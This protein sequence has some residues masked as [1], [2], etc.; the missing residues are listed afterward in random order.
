MSHIEPIVDFERGIDLSRDELRNFLANVER[1]MKERPQVEVPLK[2][3]F[4]PGCYCR[5]VVLKK[6][7][8]AMGKIHKFPCL[9]IIASGE[10]TVLSIDGPMRVKAPFTF[11]SSPGAKR[12]VYAH[13]ETVW[14][15]VQGTDETDIAKIEEIFIAKD[16]D[17]IPGIEIDVK[18][19]EGDV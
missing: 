11:V 18:K 15:T 14:V 12:L 3:T 1:E 17:E 9:T 6:G 5:E 4:S 2:H 10:V 13:E 7:T 16:Y 8:L 19:L